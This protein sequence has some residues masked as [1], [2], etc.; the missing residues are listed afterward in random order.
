MS[1]MYLIDIENQNLDLIAFL[2]EGVR[3][4]IE[5]K[6]TVFLCLITSP[7]ENTTAI[8]FK[9]DL[10]DEKGCYKDVKSTDWVTIISA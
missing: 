10:Y 5:D 1:T 4:E 2:N 3:P 7:T 8:M 6:P 9:D